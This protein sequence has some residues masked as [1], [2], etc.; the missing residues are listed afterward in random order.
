M[1]DGATVPLYYQKRVPEVLNQNEDLS[2]EF[3]ELLDEEELDDAQQAKLEN[4]F[5]KEIEVIKRDDRLETIAEDIVKHFPNRGYL[6]K[7]IMIAVD[8]FT[9]VKMYDKV[10]RFWKEEIKQLRG[11][12]RQAENEI[13]KQ[14]LQK[15]L[16]YMK[17]VEM[18]VVISEEAGE[19]KKFQ[20]EGLDIKPHRERM[21]SLDAN[22]HDIEHNFKDENHP[23]QLVFVCAMWLTGFDAPTVST[24]YLDKPMKDH[25]LMQT[26]ARANRVTPHKINDVSKTNG[27]IVD[28][29]NVFRN[30]KAALKAYAQG[31]DGTE[32]P[33]IKEKSELFKLLDDAINEGLTFC[34]TK[35]F[36]LSEVL[37]S[38]EVFKN[39][40]LFNNYADTLLS[41]DEDRKTFYVYENTIT[42]LYEASKPEIL[43]NK[44]VKVVAAFQYLRGVIESIIEQ[45]DISSISIKI[46]EL[47]DESVVVDDADNFKSN[48]FK[49]EL[50]IIKRGQV[51][52]L[53][54]IDFEA[55]KKDFGKSHYKNIEIA[56]LRAF[57]ERKIEQNA[58]AKSNPRRFRPKTPTNH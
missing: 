39:L 50:Q 26:I 30:M 44:S 41:N 32:P 56:D 21:N 7:G 58:Q 52:D 42:S 11:K 3:Y 10:Q 57:I 24:L 33:P 17:S 4:K 20:A 25:T 18:A 43:G 15:Q 2:D 40:A 1:D 48:G 22:G 35:G 38:K 37:G 46:G 14:R 54:K 19:E 34:Q 28:Y 55:L 23:L 31:E 53:S 45:K 5:A 16:D 49:P 36:D 8:K 12:I 13:H 29:Y 47:L 27:E 6:G 9:A 51:W